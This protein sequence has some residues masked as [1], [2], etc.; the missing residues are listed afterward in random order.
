MSPQEQSWVLDT[1]GQA[2]TFLPELT[3]SPQFS[4][5]HIK[6]PQPQEYGE[7]LRCLPKMLT[8]FP[9][10]GV[11]FFHLR[12]TKAFGRYQRSAHHDLQC[13]F[14]PGALGGVRENLQQF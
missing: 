10:A 8:Q 4:S 3:G 5:C 9:G 13:E 7:E 2:Q 1:L 6:E 14:L 11:G 12:R